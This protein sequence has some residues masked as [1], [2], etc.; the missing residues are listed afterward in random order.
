MCD[1]RV[2]RWSQCGSQRSR[3]YGADPARSDRR[4]AARGG[5]QPRRVRPDPRP[6]GPRAQRRRAGHVRRDVERA[7]RLQELASRCC[8]SSPR[9]GPRV[10]QGPGENAGAVDIGDGLAVV[11]KIESHNHPSAVE[12]YQGAATGVGGIVRDIFT[13][14]ARPIALLD[15]LRFGPLDV[16]T[17]RATATSSAASSAASAATATA[18]GCPTVGGEVFFARATRQPAGQRHVR[19]RGPQRSAR[20]R[21]IA[22][23]HGNPIMLVGADTG[24]DGIGGA[25]VRLADLERGPRGAAAGRA[26]RQPVPREAADGGLRRAARARRLDRRHAGPGRRRPDSST[27]RMR[28]RAAPASRSTWRVSRGASRA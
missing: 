10:L 8:A 4:A 2:A 17:G 5:P 21:A 26:G 11:F 6:P 9:T 15:S 3:G 28:R 25:N 1:P 14:G 18:S 27:G 23:G 16:P 22:R 19:R 20:P 24:R 12:P 13:M 7:L